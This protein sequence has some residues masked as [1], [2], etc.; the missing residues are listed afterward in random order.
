MCKHKKKILC[1]LARSR[2]DLA[3]TEIKRILYVNPVCKLTVNQI[4]YKYFI[5][6]VVVSHHGK[7]KRTN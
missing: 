4:S 6:F 2:L 1:Q 3:Y 7:Q 5:N